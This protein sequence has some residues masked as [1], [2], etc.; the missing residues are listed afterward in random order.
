[1]AGRRR[2]ERNVPAVLPAVLCLVLHRA[3]APGAAAG[4]TTGAGQEAVQ[5]GLAAAA[6]RM[7]KRPAWLKPSLAVPAVT[8]ARPASTFGS[9]TQAVLPAPT[10]LQ[11]LTERSICHRLVPTPGTGAPLNDLHTGLNL[12]Q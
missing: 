3:A 9:T 2:R 11:L 6:G 7:G 8:A 5:A 1:M 12:L 4:A 10:Y